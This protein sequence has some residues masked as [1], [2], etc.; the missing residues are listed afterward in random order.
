MDASSH[1]IDGAAS[2]D[3]IDAGTLVTPTDRL[4]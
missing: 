4:K 3:K 2:I 1:F